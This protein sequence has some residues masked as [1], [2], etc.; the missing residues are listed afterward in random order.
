MAYIP[1][2]LVGTIYGCFIAMWFHGNMDLQENF[3][4]ETNQVNPSLV[5]LTVVE[6]CRGL[7]FWVLSTL[8]G[9]AFYLMKWEVCCITCKCFLVLSSH[10]FMLLNISKLTNPRSVMAA[11]K[12]NI[13]ENLCLL[14]SKHLLCHIHFLVWMGYNIFIKPALV[15]N[16]WSET[17][18]EVSL[19]M[20]L[21]VQEICMHG[22]AT[23]SRKFDG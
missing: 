22:K 19:C 1:Q 2:R 5:F 11:W 8:W 9:T 17:S 16:S 21:Y 7:A 20:R 13:T 18:K 6:V 14:E 12:L 3:N 4:C 10:V 15:C 23:V